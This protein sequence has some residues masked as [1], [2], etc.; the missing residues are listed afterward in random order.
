M[1]ASCRNPVSSLVGAGQ[2]WPGRPSSREAPKSAFS[3]AF[4]CASEI[5]GGNSGLSFL[6][7]ISPAPTNQK[8]NQMIDHASSSF[9]HN[10]YSH[11]V[12]L[13]LQFMEPMVLDAANP[14]TAAIETSFS[15]QAIQFHQSFSIKTPLTQYGLSISRLEV[16]KESKPYMLFLRG[17]QSYIRPPRTPFK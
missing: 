16:L 6:G 5:S 8:P 2:P 3:C 12:R 9:H 4:S 13:G 10:T 17:I 11:T 14:Q 1:H 7:Q 15:R